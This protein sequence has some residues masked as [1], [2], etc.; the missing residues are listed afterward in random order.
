MFVSSW[1]QPRF[2]KVY[3]P[4]VSGNFY[5]FQVNNENIRARCETCSKLTKKISG[6]CYWPRSTVFIVNFEQI[7]HIVLLFP[8]FNFEQVNIDWVEVQNC[9]IQLNFKINSYYK[10]WTDS[11]SKVHG[12]VVICLLGIGTCNIFPFFFLCLK[13]IDVLDVY[14]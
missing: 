1:N 4:E 11:D 5:S 2:Y 10:H 9:K 6:R 12:N 3:W 8:L 13:K 14:N 7:S